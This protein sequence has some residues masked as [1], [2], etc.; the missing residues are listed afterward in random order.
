MYVSH[1]LSGHSFPF[2]IL[3]FSPPFLTLS[4]SLSFLK[5]HDHHVYGMVWGQFINHQPSIINYQN[6]PRRPPSLLPCAATD[7]DP[8]NSTCDVVAAL[9]IPPPP[10]PPPIFVGYGRCW[11][12]WYVLLGDFRAEGVVEAGDARYGCEEGW[13]GRGAVA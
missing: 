1:Q 10:P 2:H 12:C 7:P 5:D 9:T 3:P 11:W 4:L 13:E 8:V 6:P